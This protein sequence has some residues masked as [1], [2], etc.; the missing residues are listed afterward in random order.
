MSAERLHMGWFRHADQLLNLIR[1]PTPVGT[2]VRDY[3]RN[4]PRLGA[5]DRHAITDLAC[6]LARQP[7]LLRHIDQHLPDAADGDRSF[8]GFLLQHP[9][10]AADALNRW[11]RADA[12]RPIL[13]VPLPAPPTGPPTDVLAFHGLPTWWAADLARSGLEDVAAISA[14]AG[15]MRTR[16]PL[17]LRVNQNRMDRASVLTRLQSAA[18][19][20][21]PAPWAPTAIRCPSGFNVE[22]H[23][24]YTDGIV[25]IQDEGSQL[26]IQCMD[27]LE[28]G[29]SIIDACAGGGGKT[30]AMA[31]RWPDASLQAWEVNDR[32][33][34]D[35]RQR[36]ARAGASITCRM[37]PDRE[38]SDSD[39]ADLVLVDAPCSGSG[40]LRR[41]ISAIMDEREVRRL[42][43]VQ[44]EVLRRA[45]RWVRPAGTL[46]YATCSVLHRENEAVAARFLE[47]DPSFELI[48]VVL[49][50]SAKGDESTLVREGFLRLWPH[51]HGTDGFFAARFR[52]R[53]GR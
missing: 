25:E 16:A 36:A 15:A 5:Q 50:R 26:I 37:W 32:R 31:A 44:L 41:S 34:G 48:P 11:S 19:N 35:I 49:G 47:Q 40:T 13:E 39:R 1:P 45:S 12:L 9:D 29:S 33:F 38:P 22:G 42:Q 52:R 17:D 4:F 30:L 51:L 23:P 20:A 53:S 3:F 10:R 7:W 24:L 8:A 14:F 6:D 21:A 2:V 43:G 27:D 18:P 28:N 46:M